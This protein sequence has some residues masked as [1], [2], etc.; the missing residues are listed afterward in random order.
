MERTNTF[1]VEGSRALWELAEGC[2][3]LWNELNFE[4]RQAYIHYRK[5]PCY[6]K[7]L[8]GKYSPSVG[9]ATL[10]QIM[11]KN[12]EAWKSFSALKRLRLRGSFQSTYQSFNAE[13]LETKL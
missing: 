6:S 9:S 1:M 12:N 8:Y 4:R 7:H 10:Q 13:V 3:G 11:N 5:S 2:S